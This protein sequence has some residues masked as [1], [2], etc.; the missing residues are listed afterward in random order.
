MTAAQVGERA[1]EPDS[2][3]RTDN[4]GGALPTPQA[5][6]DAYVT[7]LQANKE[8][9]ATLELDERIEILDAILIDLNA[10]GDEWV[11]ASI[12]AKGNQGNDAAEAEEW[13]ML[14]YALRLVRLLGE[15]LRDI[16]R[17][18]RPQIPG[19]LDTL[20]DGQVRARVFPVDRYD[21]IMFSGMTA[22]VWMQPGISIE[23]VV[24]GQARFY[25]DGSGKGNVVLVLAAGNA[26]F[27]V[28]TDFMY[29]LFVEGSV[30][31]LKMNPVN[32]YLGPIIAKGFRALIERNFL[33]I[34]YGGAAEGN[35]LCHHPSVDELHMTGS[36]KTYDAIVF[37]PG[38]EG[39]QR[40]AQRRPLVEKRFTGEL[41]NITPV[42]VVPGP[43]TPKEIDYWGAKL[44]SWLII[45]AGFNCLTPR[46]IIQSA[47]WE[48]RQSLIQ[49][50]G[51]TLARV[52]TRKAY[53][54]GAQQRHEEFLAAHPTCQQYGAAGDGKLPW[55]FIQDVD[56]NNTDDI[57]FKSEA[58]CG[59]FAETALEAQDAPSFLAAA[60]SFVNEHLWG[61]LTAT[62]VVHPESLKDAQ[63]A[64]AV[65]RAVADLHYGMVLINQFAGLGVF[66]MTAPWGAYP[67]ND[68]YDIQSGTGFTFNTLMFDNPQKCVVRFPFKVA[69]DPMSLQSRTVL[70]VSRRLADLQY[71]PSIW[72]VPGILWSAIRS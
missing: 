9:W 51:Q 30:V 35:Y 39:A 49:V 67:G 2:S 66:A 60:V 53:Y 26:S 41:G 15:S 16:Q 13:T 50:I 48:H 18:G 5:E 21:S 68:M 3:A 36:N 56:A 43:W 47:A 29:K 12:L 22:E 46:V 20:P 64:T 61:N 28:T 17:S 37:G 63:V 25:R 32:S 58:F 38:E 4:F 8:T 54:P 27:L 33:R 65:E 23:E 31:I 62:L 11:S 6:L 1:N 70:D 59:L 69:P 72:K 24:D 44:A 57:C 52:E 34:V 40:K 71:R 45:N 7:E 19:S 42:I 14:S 55:T 10:V